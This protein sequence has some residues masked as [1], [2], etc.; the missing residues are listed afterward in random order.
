M[1]RK[2]EKYSWILPSTEI[3]WFWI[4]FA[5]FIAK[6]K[7]TLAII[8]VATEQDKQWYANQLLP[9]DNIS[10]EAGHSVYLSMVSKK[11]D[12]DSNFISE[13]AD[14]EAKYGVTMFRNFVLA[15]RHFGRGYLQAGSGHPN[16]RTAEASNHVNL[17]RVFAEAFNEVEM[18]FERYP[19]DGMYSY[20]GGLGFKSKVF[21]V[22]ARH[23]KISFRAICPA[24]IRGYVYWAV[25][26][27]EKHPKFSYAELKLLRRSLTN[28]QLRELVADVQTRPL[29]HTMASH[30]RFL[31]P[32]LRSKSY[33]FVAKLAFRT[34]AQYTYW[35]LKGFDKIKTGYLMTSKVKQI[36][37]EPSKFKQLD[38]YSIKSV[39][40]IPPERK[41][42]YFALQQE[43]EVST[44]G[45][46]QNDTNQF[47]IIMELSLQLPA[48]CLLVVKEHIY[49][50][51]ARPPDFYKK[52]AHLHNVLLVSPSISG[53]EII[54][55]ADVIST[56]SSSA[57]FE[58]AVLGKPTIFFWDRCPIACLPHVHVMSRFNG[59]EKIQILLREQSY[60]AKKRRQIDG[61]LYLEFLRNNAMD[62]DSIDFYGRGKPFNLNE[63]QS[64]TAALL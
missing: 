51:A 60:S 1:R 3:R 21:A 57:G 28:Q 39:S 41:I 43:P 25:D 56:I 12:Q 11:G 47:N 7:N 40:Q 26:E 54:D 27:F 38:K 30:K 31:E 24:R 20:H 45:L 14:I 17:C 64:F 6:E 19:P 50:I 33:I 42:L 23:H 36:I 16:S 10:I 18:L 29:A 62:T 61:A 46:A 4:G 58:S 2:K 34:I 15:D 8:F 9:S 59:L 35:K 55:R 44:I 5:R 13:A 32:K 37:A 63:M 53:A 49:A 48:D 22:L 52:I